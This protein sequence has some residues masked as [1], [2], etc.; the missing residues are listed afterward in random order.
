MIDTNWIDIRHGM[1]LNPGPW[2]YRDNE[3]GVLFYLEY[4]MIKEAAGLP[5]EEDIAAFKQILENIRTYDGANTRIMGLFDRGPEESLNPNRDA[6]RAISH[7]NMTAISAFDHR[8]GDGE[9]AKHIAK[10]GTPRLL[11]DNAYPHDQRIKTI[12][13]PTD[14]F[15]WSM[16]SNS[17]WLKA[18]NMVWGPFFLLRCLLSNLSKPQDTS[19]K[20]LNFVRFFAWKDSN[21]FMG[22]CWKIYSAMMR[23]QYGVNWVNALMNIY[24][25]NPAHPNRILS[26]GLQL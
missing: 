5:I 11:Y 23:R 13:W 9:E 26:A 8:Y 2:P 12:Q 25:L 24:F 14:V 3:N 22:L 19:G 18:I 7:D 4:I 6:I 17:S 16:C 15:F 20:L 10:W 21:R 1:S